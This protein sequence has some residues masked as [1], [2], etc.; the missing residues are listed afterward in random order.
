VLN[1]RGEK[2]LAPLQAMQISLVI[3]RHRAG[4]GEAAIPRMEIRRNPRC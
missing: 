1:N 2:L 3:E 4:R